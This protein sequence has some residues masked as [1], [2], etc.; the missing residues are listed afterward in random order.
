[1]LMV[2]FLFATQTFLSASLCLRCVIV[3]FYLAVGQICGIFCLI[4][5]DFFGNSSCVSD[6]KNNWWI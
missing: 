4:D 5:I 2:I 3:G 6:T 1:M